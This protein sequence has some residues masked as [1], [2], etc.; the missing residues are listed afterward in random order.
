[1]KEYLEEYA[2]AILACIAGVALFGLMAYLV[3]DESGLRAICK[4]FS[5]SIG[6]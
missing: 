1:M 4:L 5:D 6:G 3:C 2:W